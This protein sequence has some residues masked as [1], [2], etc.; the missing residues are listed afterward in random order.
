MIEITFV[1]SYKRQDSIYACC[2]P[3]VGETVELEYL[4]HEVKEVH[5]DIIDKKLRATV[6]VDEIIKEDYR[7]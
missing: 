5:Y 4:P 7:S 2:V 3:R 1:G 6:Y